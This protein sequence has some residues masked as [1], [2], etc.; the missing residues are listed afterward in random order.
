MVSV[1]L[2]KF[3][4]LV[5]RHRPRDFGLVLDEEGFV[6]LDAL[7]AVVEQRRG[8]PNTLADVLEVV[9]HGQPRRFEIR[10]DKIRATY[11]HSRR[12]APQVV[13]PPAEPPALL[14]HGTHPAALPG[15]RKQGLRA[16]ARQYVHLSTT[17]ERALEV[18]ARRTQSP[19][20]LTIRAR[21]AYAAG[22]VF[23]SPEPRHYLAQ[24]IPPE[25]IDFPGMERSAGSCGD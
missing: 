18:A 14:Y 10:G 3:M 13:Y 24:A 5:L 11:G 19:V 23:H 21:D 16:M 17:L 6:P 12:A 4:S 9:E 7:V 22:V 20:I 2:S 15:I 25:Y 1:K 8:M